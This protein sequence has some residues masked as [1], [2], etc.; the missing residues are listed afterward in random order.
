MNSFLLSNI[1]KKVKSSQTLIMAEKAKKLKQLGYNVRNLSIGEPDFST[2]NFVL[3]AATKAIDEV[4]LHAQYW[5]SSYEMVKFC[6][7]KPIILSYNIA[8]FK[9][10]CNTTGFDNVSYLEELQVIVNILKKKKNINKKECD[11]KTVTLSVKSIL[12]SKSFSLTGLS[13]GYMGDAEWF[14]KACVKI[15]CKN[16]IA[17]K[18]AISVVE[19][20]TKNF[21]KKIVKKFREKRKLLI[22]LFK[23]FGVPDGAT[24]FFK[25]KFNTKVSI[26]TVSGSAF[27]TSKKNIL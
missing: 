4:I 14:S 21:I 3:I 25:K 9:T 18:A 6:N 19:T 5:V 11:E 2:Q 20:S 24:S 26:S 13:I 17:H 23:E 27:A 22:K 16:Y 1:I 10:Q 7:A 15:K 12:L 8:L